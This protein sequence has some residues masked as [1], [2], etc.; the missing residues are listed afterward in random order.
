MDNISIDILYED[1]DIIAV[2]KPSGLLT[3]PSWLTKKGT[4]NLATMLKH[5]FGGA[6]VHTVHRLDRATSGVILV[7][8]NKET[9]KKLSL[10]FAEHRVQKTYYC[11][12]RGFAPGSGE[13]SHPLQYIHD[14][15]AE[16]F[17]TINKEAQDAITHY[18]TL[19][20][21][22]LPIAVGK[23]PTARYSL[24]QAMP[25][26]GRKHQLRRHF[27]H[28]LCPIV[29]D[30]NYGEGRHNKLYRDHFN[31]NRLLLMAVSIRFIHPS[32]SQQMTIKAPLSEQVQVLFKEFGWQEFTQL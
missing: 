2:N 6:P 12:V 10:D 32:T 18:S 4:E 26:T 31:I 23:W 24:I 28:I 27:K 21:V 29:G 1:D 3:H 13:I 8:K 16:P 9:A 20:N 15:K 17:A 5:Y 22:Q 30:T 7:A 11:V 19:A 14:K 25:K